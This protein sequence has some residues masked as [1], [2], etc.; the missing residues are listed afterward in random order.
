MINPPFQW[1]GAKWRIAPWVASFLPERP[2]YVEPFCG[3]AAVFFQMP[4]RPRVAVLNDLNGDI[5]NFYRVLREQPEQLCLALELTPYAREE[6]LLS[7]KDDDD[8]LERARR[9]CTFTWLANGL[10]F[11]RKSTGWRITHDSSPIAAWQRVPDRVWLVA[12]R[13]RTAFIEHCPALD[14]L[15][16]YRS[17]DTTIY[18]DPPYVKST[19][20]GSYYPHEMTDDDH[21]ALLDAADQ[22]PGPVIIS[23][24][25][26]DLYAARLAH[27]D[28]FTTTTQV[29]SGDQR[30]EYIWINQA[31]KIS[32][33]TRI[34]FDED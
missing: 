20:S 22:H 29:S 7:R 16:R 30:T 31:A 4:W 9:F 12:E 2:C 13:L 15:A 25:Y 11:N 6:Y 21:R 27:W 18:L 28:V 32:Q 24:Y 34:P 17:S 1:P 5:V 33:Q 23:G 3:S 19:I 14:L 8:P 26:S 10:R